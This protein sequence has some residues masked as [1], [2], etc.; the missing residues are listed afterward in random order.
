MISEKVFIL[1]AYM[2]DGKKDPSKRYITLNC[3]SIASGKLFTTFQEYK[4]SLNYDASLVCDFKNGVMPIIEIEY[5][6]DGGRVRVETLKD[7]GIV[8]EITKTE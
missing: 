7:T 4:S 2:V 3:A 8:G 1:S 5:S 6:V